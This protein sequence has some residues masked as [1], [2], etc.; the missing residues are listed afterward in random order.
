MI[1]T[2]IDAIDYAFRYADDAPPPIFTLR[3]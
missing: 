2:L 1:I 3:H